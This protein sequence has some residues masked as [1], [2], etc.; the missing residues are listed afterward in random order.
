M[1]FVVFNYFLFLPTAGAVDASSRRA[2]AKL[3]RTLTDENALDPMIVRELI[4]HPKWK[5]H[6][7][8]LN[9]AVLEQENKAKSRK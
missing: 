6:F 1:V 2:K 5:R 3:S 8:K 9:E 7:N 4:N